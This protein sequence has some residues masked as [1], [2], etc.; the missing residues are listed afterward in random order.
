[1]LKTRNIYIDT[2]AFVASNYF[3][4]ENLKRLSEFAKAGV[5]KLFITEITKR[6]IIDNAASSLAEAVHEINEFKKKIAGK[7]V[8]KNIAHF[9]T[10]LDLPKLELNTQ[11]AQIAEDLDKFILDSGI[12]VIPYDTADLNEVVSN[13]FSQAKPFGPG[14]KKHEFP[15]AI[16]IS[17]LKHWCSK[18]GEKMYLISGD[19][20]MKG[21]GISSLLSIES[22]KEMLNLI[23]KQNSADEVARMQL[24]DR[25]FEQFKETI[26]KEIR[27]KFEE[28]LI[29]ELGFDISVEDVEVEEITLFPYS[30]VEDR[31]GEGETTIQLD[32]DVHFSATVIYQD[33]SF[34]FYDKEDDKYFGARS[35]RKRISTGSTQTAEI[36]IEELFL[37]VDEGSELEDVSITCTYTSIPDAGYITDEL[38]GYQF[39]Y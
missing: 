38:E 29:D 17:S 18:S 10:Y 7:R 32:Y 28:N 14:K 3:Q 34:G 6:E 30:I 35:S 37:D 31:V 9:K 12:E 22:L 24:I 27:L 20:D 26:I 21:L 16:V 39:N 13:Y 5:V 25:A 23:N 4:S 36:V 2:E 8:L 1:M 15:D 11:F 33:Y 19:N